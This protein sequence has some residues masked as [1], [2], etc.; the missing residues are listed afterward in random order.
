M[1]IEAIRQL[2]DPAL[3]IDAYQ[4]NDLAFYKALVLSSAAEGIETQLILRRSNK[5]TKARSEANSFAI[6]AYLNGEWSSICDGNITLVYKEN[7][8]KA[9]NYESHENARI[10]AQN[11]ITNC[12]SKIPSA[13][14]YK[15]LAGYGFDFGPTFQP[16][17]GIRFNNAGE[18][19]GNIKL[20]GWTDKV[21]SGVVKDHVIHP[22]ALDGLLRLGMATVSGGGWNP[23][24]TMAPTQLRSLWISHDLLARKPQSEV[25]LYA[26]NTFCGFRESH[27]DIVALDSNHNVQISVQD[28]RETALNTIDPTPKQSGLGC[29]RFEW[30]PDPTIMEKA[31]LVEYCKTHTLNMGTE[32]AAYLE[33][34][35]NKIPEL[36]VLEVNL[37]GD[38]TSHSAFHPL[39]SYV[40]AAKDGQRRLLCQRYT[41]AD[42]SPALLKHVENTC[43]GA[44]TNLRFLPLAIDRDPLEQGIMAEQFDVVICNIDLGDAAV[45]KMVL[46]NIRK[47][48][49]PEGTLVLPEVHG[50]GLAPFA[51]LSTTALNSLVT[52]NGFSGLDMALRSS[53]RTKEA[54]PDVTISHLQTKQRSESA[55]QNLVIVIEEESSEQVQIAPQI[56][57][58]LKSIDGSSC[59]IV[60]L[61]CLRDQDLKG[62]FCIFLPE[63]GRPFL[64][65]MSEEEFLMLTNLV[66]SSDGILW[67]TQGCGGEPSRPEMGLATGF[68]RNVGSEYWGTRFVE[69]ALNVNSNLMQT[70]ESILTVYRRS[71]LIAPD[72]VFEPEYREID[73]R[74]CVSRAVEN[75]D[76]KREVE[77]RTVKQTPQ[78]QT[79]GS[80][81]SRAI[82]IDVGSAGFLNTLHFKDDNLHST[83]LREGE[84]EIKVEAVGL[85]FK[86][87][88]IALGQLPGN[89][90]GC[91]CAGFV[92]RVGTNASFQPGERVLCCTNTGAY[93]TFARA[94]S[95]S[96]TKL[97]SEM[98]FQ[99]AAAIP[100]AFCTAYYALCTT[101]RLQAGESILI[102]SG[103]GG[104]GQAAIQLA[105]RVNATVFTTVGTDD[106]K[107]FLVEK[108]GIPEQQIFSSRNIAFADVLKHRHKGVDVVLNSLIGEGLRASWLCVRQF[109]RFVELG[110]ADM[111]GRESLSMSPLSHNVT[112]SSIDLG[113]LMDEAKPMMGSV[114]A[115]VTALLNDRSD[116]I[117]SPLPVN[118]FQVSELEQAFRAMQSGQSIGKIVV[119]MNDHAV[120]PVFI[121]DL[122]GK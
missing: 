18:A 87:V 1:A 21:A 110:K 52:S 69:L 90:L 15:N 117:T 34:L 35:A 6:Y 83:I 55:V 5:S 36:D 12:K 88:M 111:Q 80:D 116:P 19:V 97:P 39:I 68:G 29:Y 89:T 63:M 37:S 121:L 20:D 7:P 24:P 49:K 108:Y 14:F 122:F 66:G 81:P 28:W 76:M 27:F 10:V 94:H 120:I 23:I 60:T 72:D 77:V 105:Q 48:L 64:A 53:F 13:Q 71:L 54:E 9:N 51:S 62:S 57:S 22:T 107:K 74:L 98:S 32:I 99:T 59:E 3:S 26:R 113:L 8:S 102:H 41:Y 104:V 85:N 101:A 31:Q 46:Q 79:F 16:L 11:G 92:S 67:V 91:E 45:L 44:A 119:E 115:A 40:E 70:T 43:Q 82:N 86:D 93:S 106:K 114:M 42:A 73:G 118:V 17:E 84:V 96:T 100:T 112:F 95:T 38:H 33:L 103:A 58:K 56:R 109:G 25:E 65:N 2:A 78:M 75:Q 61:G 4:L 47:I 50:S 30:K